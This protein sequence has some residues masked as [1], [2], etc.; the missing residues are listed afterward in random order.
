MNRWTHSLLAVC[1]LAACQRHLEGPAPA[2]EAFDLVLAGGR[3]M[4][5]ESGL[6]RRLSVG[7]RSGRI[8]V[9]SSEPLVGG[10]ETLDVSG[11]VV[12]PGFIDL[13]SHG[14][15]PFG[16]SLQAQ[17]GVTTQLEQ[18]IG[19][20]PVARWYASRE[21]H[22]PINFGAAVGHK[23]ARVA[24]MHPS[25]DEETSPPLPENA[26][27][28][29]R[30]ATED[31]MT[32]LAAMLEEGLREGALGIGF[33]VAY[34][35]GASDEEIERMFR[36]AGAR[37]AP[38]FIHL[39]GHGAA[40][41]LAAIAMAERAGVPLHVVHI[42]SSAPNDVRQAL[43]AIAAARARGQDVTTEAYPYT[44]GQTRLESPIFDDGWRERRGLDYGDIQW[45]A[46]GERLT[47]AS[48]D[49]YR[50]QGG[51]PVML[52]YIPQEA[53]DFAIA[54]PGVMI[55]SDTVRYEQGKGHPRGSGT[56]ARVLGRY[57]RE[58]RALG[59]M[60]ALAKMTIMPARRLEGICPAMRRK[61]RIAVGADAD[62]TVFDPDRLID[63]STYENGA[64]P[65]AGIPHVLVG[66]TFVVRNGTLVEGAY[67]GRPV[68]ATIQSNGR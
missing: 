61:G 51:G 52:H 28:A 15:D 39:R 55:A 48:F 50:K 58:K 43:E 20:L 18:E 16:A 40:F 6:D 62:I 13:H 60:E 59:L 46:T 63:R 49:A 10:R 68:R 23:P 57:V 44:A 65:S 38:V 56:F 8:A 2:S 42:T 12:A 21:G 9:L 41:V 47:K 14:Q 17:D 67:P 19:V 24:L 35:P 3:V 22:A 33:H 31:E 25:Y 30:A 27:F 36:V 37:K 7:I 45:V 26:D 11:L 64:V 32:R 5:P 4:N 34:T 66:G 1:L 54:A 29:R 53:A